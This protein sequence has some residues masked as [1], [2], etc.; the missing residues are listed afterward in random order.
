M[1]SGNLNFLEPP[2]PL[3]ACNRT[4]LPLS[5]PLHSAI[6]LIINDCSENDNIYVAQDRASWQAPVNVAMNLRVP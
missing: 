6:F 3:Q 5:L 4:A 1:K 2:G